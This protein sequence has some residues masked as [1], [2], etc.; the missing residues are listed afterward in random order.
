MS[1]PKLRRWI[2]AQG[3]TSEL[4]PG[5]HIK[6]LHPDAPYPV[7]VAASPSDQGVLTRMAAQFR[8]ALREGRAK[9]P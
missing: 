2:A 5:G 7:F 8:K 9:P 3:W 6:C 1:T 4:T